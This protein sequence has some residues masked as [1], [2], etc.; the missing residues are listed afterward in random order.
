MSAIS[1][2][3]NSVAGWGGGGEVDPEGVGV[4][5]FEVSLKIGFS[6]YQYIIPMTLEHCKGSK[7]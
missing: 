4:Q 2:P 6:F 3:V 1:I 7:G 5:I